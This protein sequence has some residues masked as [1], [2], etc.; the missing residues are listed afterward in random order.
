MQDG[1]VVNGTCERA[2]DLSLFLGTS[3]VEGEN[4]LLKV[5]Y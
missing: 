4:G 3:T 5:V 1:K 2:D